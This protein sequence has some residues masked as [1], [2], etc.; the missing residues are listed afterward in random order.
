MTPALHEASFYEAQPG[1]RALCTL[2]PH[3]CRIADGSRGACA[4]R[5][6]DHGV[7]YT[8]AYDRVVTSTIE[9]VE[10]KPFFHF[11]PG[12]HA[13][14]IATVGCN[15]QCAFCQNWEIA[16]WPREDLPRRL[17][18]DHG[19]AR[20]PLEALAS[21]IPGR[22]RSPESIVDAAVDAGASSIA[23][24]FTEPTI[25]LELAY[26]TA[27]QA[28]ARG[29]K[30]LFVTNGFI[31]E[32]PARKIATVLD[33]ANVD[34][35]FF[36]EK[37]YRR[38][39]RAGLEPILDAIRLYRALGVWVEVT[40]LVIPGVNDSDHELRKIAEFIQSVGPEIPWHVSQFFPAYKMADRPVTPV[41]T[42]RRARDIGLQE[43]LRYVYEGNVP[44]EGHEDTICPAC[45]TVLIKR[46]G[47]TVRENR[48]TDGC[49]P[50][51]AT[52]VDGVEMSRPRVAVS[53]RRP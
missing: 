34:L 26:D 47:F 30:N 20:L 37:S 13:Y 24:T 21:A 35:K 53:G 40:T 38:I 4:V 25:F 19:E 15:L 33:A 3:D 12:S 22:A 31:S 23:Y 45:R 7:L 5:F 42:L 43:G 39:S 32:A 2:C 52:P 46:S 14:S 11:K 44:G 41:D 27:V 6:N 36:R 10:K 28:R 50:A 17:G 1:G 48:I 29:L 8:L 16:Q 49:C 51:C 18:G 9:P